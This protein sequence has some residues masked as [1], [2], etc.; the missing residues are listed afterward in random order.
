MVMGKPKGRPKSWKETCASLKEDDYRIA[1]IGFEW[2]CEWISCWLSRW[3][4]LEVLE[5]LGKLTILISL[6]LWI[7]PGFEERKQATESA[8]QSAADARKSRHYV[9][10]QTLNSAMGK[11]GNA[12]RADAL[13]DLS[14]DGIPMDGISLSGHVVLLGPL[15]LANARMA[16]A[17][18]SD[19][20][21]EKINCS[22]AEFMMSKWDNAKSIYCDFRGASFWAVTFKDVTFNSCDFGYTDQG[23]TQRPSVFIMQF[24]GNHSEFMMCNFAGTD[25]QMGIWNSVSFAW[26]NFAY[27]HL[28]I[29]H[30][31]TNVN[32]EYCNLYGATTSSP[33]FIKWAYHQPVVFTNIISM[34]E[35]YHCVTNRLDYKAGSPEF[36]AWASN[37]FTTFINTN[38]PQAWLNWSRDNLKN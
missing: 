9:A 1:F 4:F 6:I 24:A 19:A 34:Q 37:Q 29:V 30:I 27:A 36:M 25:S 12:G 18:F 5:Y 14:Q 21:F 28:G 8:K 26:C 35:W 22:N 10:W 31:G 16:S 13:Q 23:K 38:N 3:A 20:Q 7:Y 11:P 15:N 17:D 33:D 32:F 2:C